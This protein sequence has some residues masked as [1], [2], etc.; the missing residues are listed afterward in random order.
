MILKIFYS[1]TCI[2]FEK[3]LTKLFEFNEIS[4]EAIHFIMSEFSSLK[5]IEY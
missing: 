1:D 5:M 3:N 2:Y 4:V